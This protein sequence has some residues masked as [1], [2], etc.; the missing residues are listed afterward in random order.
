MCNAVTSKSGAHR[1]GPSYCLSLAA[2][3][4]QSQIKHNR[5]L[6]VYLRYQLLSALK[7]RNSGFSEWYATLRQH[8]Y[9]RCHSQEPLSR[10]NAGQ[11]QHSRA[12]CLGDIDNIAQ[13]RSAKEIQRFTTIRDRSPRRGRGHG[14]AQKHRRGF[15]GCSEVDYWTSKVGDQSEKDP[16][17]LLL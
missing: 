11:S 15:F 10:D 12:S 5:G 16:R 7:L 4:P 17:G 1:A 9:A 13:N 14:A 6:F 3:S 2:A 8:N